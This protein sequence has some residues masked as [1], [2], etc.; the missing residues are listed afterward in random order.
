MRQLE[1]NKRPVA[2]AQRDSVNGVEVYGTPVHLKV[3]FRNT[4]SAASME[5]LG[6]AVEGS[7]VLFSDA[8][9]ASYFHEFDRVYV[10]TDAPLVPDTYAET[11]DYVVEAVMPGLNGVEIRLKRVNR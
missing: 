10:F 5:G 4:R 11:A 6:E 8:Q 9:T 7:L 3:N 2:V 1:R